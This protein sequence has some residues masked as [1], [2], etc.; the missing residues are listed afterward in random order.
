MRVTTCVRRIMASDLAS[1]PPST[2]M[3]MASSPKSGRFF[4]T[5]CLLFS[6]VCYFRLFHLV[7]RPPGNPM[8]TPLAALYL[9]ICFINGEPLLFYCPSRVEPARFDSP[10]K[11]V[12]SRRNDPVTLSCLSKGDDHINIIWLHNNV[13]IGLSNYR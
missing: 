1:P 12:S 10:M 3:L 9:E 4:F 6:F 13:R 11:N 5:F 8:P 2:S 7:L